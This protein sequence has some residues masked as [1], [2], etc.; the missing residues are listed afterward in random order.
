MKVL[1]AGHK[2]ELEHLDGDDH[3]KIVFVKRFRGADN[4]QGTN[5]QELLRVLI[6]RVEFLDKEIPWEGNKEILHHLR[7]A[8]V[9]HES[10]AL[11]RKVQ[12]GDIQK[13]EHVK[14]SRRDGHWVVYENK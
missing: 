10:R 3:Q 14:Y 7:M 5:N 12:K 11:M 13:P 9:L 6:D 1:D 2:Y 4:H 8:L